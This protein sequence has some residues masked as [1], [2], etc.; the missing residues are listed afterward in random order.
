[1]NPKL[2]DTGGGSASSSASPHHFGFGQR[3]SSIPVF[4]IETKRLLIAME[5]VGLASAILNFVDIGFKIVRNTYEIYNSATGATQQNIHVSMV[6]TDLESVTRRLSCNPSI[7]CDKELVDLSGKCRSLSQ[8]LVQ[9]LQ[10]LQPKNDSRRQ[11]FA[12][13]WAAM[14]KQKDVDAIEKRLV[15]YR[16]QIILHLLLVLW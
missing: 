10:T 1:M 2:P 13:A 7:T 11:T 5:A 14:R 16:E 6:I 3:Y 4:V 9:L 15:Q 8:D 12:A